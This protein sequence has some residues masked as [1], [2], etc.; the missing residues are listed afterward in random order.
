M[1]EVLVILIIYV[2]YYWYN[3]DNMTF[4]KSNIDNKYY[5]VRNLPDIKVEFL[6]NI[7]NEINEN[8][9]TKKHKHSKQCNIIEEFTK[10]KN[11]N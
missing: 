6:E 3:Y 7:V 8:K 9:Y 4:M 11:K 2:I 5:M 1:K 10:H